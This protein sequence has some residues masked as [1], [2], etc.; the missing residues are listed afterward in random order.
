MRIG[1]LRKRLTLKFEVVVND[2]VYGSDSVW[3]TLAEMWGEI[4]P[5][6]N[7]AAAAANSR[8]I[9]H[10]I[11]IRYDDLVQPLAG[12]KIVN[13]LRT[14]TIHGVVDVDEGD[15]W[16]DLYAEEGGLLE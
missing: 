1:N 5:Y 3:E 16:W 9:T 15:R 6:N 14:F 10:V 13:G 11:R 4:R 8:R 12:M 7:A 2:G